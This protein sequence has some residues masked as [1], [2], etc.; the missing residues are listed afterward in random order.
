MSNNIPITSRSQMEAHADKILE[1]MKTNEK[2]VVLTADLVGSCKLGKIEKEFPDR[3]INVGIAEQ[4]MVAMAAGL[5][6]EGM[7]P[8]VHSF[9][10]FTSLRS[11]E[12][13]RTDLFYNEL[14]VKVVG[15]HS[16][17]STGP[18]GSTHFSLED[19]GVIRAMPKS[20]IVVP[21]DSIAAEKAAESIAKVPYPVYIRLDR[22]PLTNIYDDTFEFQIGKGNVLSDGEEVVLFAAGITVSLCIEATRIIEEQTN[23]SVAVIDMYTIKP[24]DKDLVERY[25]SKCKYSFTVE[26]HN[27]YGGLGSAVAEVIAES[28]Y[29]CKLM[30]MGIQDFYPMGGPIDYNRE[31]LGLTANNIANTVMGKIGG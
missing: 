6:H 26:E 19:I 5:A 21:A 13:V 17:V 12:Q 2:I 10:V 22:N 31:K 1:M 7:I 18:A 27:I 24:I 3:F 30:R 23:I 20:T 15:T 8:F 9:S 4:N 16:G 29:S 14:N 25:I 28:G 11:C